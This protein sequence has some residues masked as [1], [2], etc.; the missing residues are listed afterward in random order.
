MHVQ[1]VALCDQAIISADGRPS[2]INIFDHLQ[3]ASLPTVVPRLA[4]AARLL[5]TSDEVGSTHKVA[6]AITS[7]SGEEIGAPGGDISLPQAPVEI[8]TVSVD[9]PLQFDMFEL[10]E[11]GRY[12]FLLRFDDKPVGAAQ[13][14]V[15]VSAVPQRA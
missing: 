6:V 7:P 14:A 12:T 5:F 11:A 4:F 1:F 9:L 10:K 3:V 13:L 2:L 8:D 15:R